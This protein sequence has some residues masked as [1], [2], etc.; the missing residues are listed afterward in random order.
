MTMELGQTA[1]DTR[2]S[3][4][5]TVERKRKQNSNESNSCLCRTRQQYTLLDEA[6]AEGLR[7]FGEFCQGGIGVE[8]ILPLCAQAICTRVLRLVRRT[9]A[10]CG[11]SLRVKID[12]GRH[13]KD[14]CFLGIKDAALSWNSLFVVLAASTGWREA[15]TEDLEHFP[16]FFFVVPHRADPACLFLLKIVL[17]SKR[18]ASFR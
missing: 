1:K 5:S 12:F 10:P 9:A 8:F 14:G 4:G 15:M 3:V 18:S 16:S 17:S 11:L 7:C 13:V 6:V 2:T